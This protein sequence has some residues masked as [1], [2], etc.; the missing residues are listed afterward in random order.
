M[1]KL[2]S[3][4]QQQEKDASTHLREMLADAYN[5]TAVLANKMWLLDEAENYHLE[6]LR[7]MEDIKEQAKEQAAKD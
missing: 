3:D 5:R 4:L 6:A 2:V 1:D 7:I